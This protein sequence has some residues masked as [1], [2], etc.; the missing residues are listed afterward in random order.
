[1][2]KDTFVVIMAGGV[3]SRFWP[4]SRNS[5]PKQFLDI[6]G[7]GKSLIQM[8]YE[9]SLNIVPA[10]NI[11]VITNANYVDQVA[12]H[13]PELPAENII[14]EPARKNTGPCVAYI[15]F[16]IQA[17]C[18]NAMILLLPSDHMISNEMVFV[19]SLAK[20]IQF[21]DAEGG[22]MTL[23]MQAH[24]ANTGYGY[25]Q[26]GPQIEGKNI[27]KVATFK[28]K[29]DAQTAQE[30]IDSGD[31]VWNAGIFLFKAGDILHQFSVFAPEIYQTLYGE[32]IYG[33]PEE[34]AFINERYP[35]VTSIS[36]DY[37]IMEK[38]SNIY[39]MPMDIGWSDLGTWKSLFELQ[40]K[41]ED[42]IVTNVKPEN[43]Y[44]EGATGLLLQLPKGKKAVIS[45]VDNL[46]IVDTNDVLMIWPKDR[47]QE[48]KQ[49]KDE[50]ASNW[51]LE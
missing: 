23:G 35:Q 49:V 21:I 33:S 13:L 43:Y 15:S 6:L 25:I 44:I 39:C 10:S 11:F 38:S 42:E 17:I 50:V 4:A 37:A 46:L 32:N 24:H 29:P 16:H 18:S 22:I 36:I 34:E 40:A 20:A 51:N 27:Y 48:I 5:Q 9:R 12:E 45:G 14:S 47:E 7:V 2:D 26:T 30:Y 1:M 28:E 31:F 3:G 19:R 8:T 41:D